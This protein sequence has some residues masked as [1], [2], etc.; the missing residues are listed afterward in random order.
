MAS[1]QEMYNLGLFSARCQLL[2]FRYV[3]PTKGAGSEDADKAAAIDAAEVTAMALNNYISN[4]RGQSETF[5]PDR[6]LDEYKKVRRLHSHH[7]KEDV[8][9][10]AQIVCCWFYSRF[11][12]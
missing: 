9:L 4:Q 6:F 10:L 12:Y 7:V 2:A 8:Q 1:A 11:I 3:E 5:S